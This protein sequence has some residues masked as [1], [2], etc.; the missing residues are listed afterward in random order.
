MLQNDETANPQ[1]LAFNGEKLNIPTS[2][3]RTVP[4]QLALQIRKQPPK[5]SKAVQAGFG[6]A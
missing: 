6:E 1:C 2:V 4:E 5:Q 3:F